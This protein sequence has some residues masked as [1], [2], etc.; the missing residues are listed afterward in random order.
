MAGGGGG[1]AAA[2]GPPPA[3]RGGGRVAGCAVA[4]AALAPGCRVIGVEP[5]QADD[6][7]RSFR[8]G[9]LQTV[10]EPETVADGARTPSLGE[11]T[12]PLIRRH[13]HDFVTVSE[14]AILEGMFFLWTRLKVVV[15][16]TGALAAAALL[17]GEV[18]CQGA[19][20]GVVLSGGNVD[21]AA[22][23]AFLALL[24]KR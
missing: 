9:V 24:G 16:P 21:P 5:A 3:R 2:G 19:R 13:V 15:E 14:E 6:A 1:P 20:V 17:A 10:H 11:L 4:A 8:T 22:V 7:A 18:S 23:P 12:F